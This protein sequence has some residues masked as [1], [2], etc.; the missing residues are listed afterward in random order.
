[1][2]YPVGSSGSIDSTKINFFFYDDN[3]N[4]IREVY[5]EMVLQNWDLNILPNTNPTY[6]AEFPPTNNTLDTSLSLLAIFP[7]IFNWQ[8]NYYFL[9]LTITQIQYLSRIPLGF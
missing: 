7:H 3:E 6:F 5:N 4:N 2:H 9:K 1:M 8:R